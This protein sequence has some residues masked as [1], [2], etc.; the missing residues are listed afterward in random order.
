MKD[1]SGEDGFSHFSHRRFL[2]KGDVI[3][4]GALGLLTVDARGGDK[5]LGGSWQP[6][7]ETE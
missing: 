4:L 6:I 2:A 5:S 7:E 1:L 3:Q